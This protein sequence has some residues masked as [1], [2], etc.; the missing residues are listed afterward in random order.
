[1]KYIKTFEYRRKTFKIGDIVWF[2]NFNSISCANTTVV[3]SIGEILEPYRDD[4]YIID[5]GDIK[6]NYAYDFNI[7][8]KATKTEIKNFEKLKS[9]QYLQF[10]ILREKERE[11][12][13]YLNNIKKYNL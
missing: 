2:R 12:I 6:N 1:M 13:E 9:E 10:E 4:D 8:R 7:L 5:Y 3:E 11:R